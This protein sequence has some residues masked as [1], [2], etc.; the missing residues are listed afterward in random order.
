MSIFL[1]D[2]PR[3]TVLTFDPHDP[4]PPFFAPVVLPGLYGSDEAAMEAG[5]HE[6]KSLR[7]GLRHNIPNLNMPLVAL[8]DY[9]G[10]RLIATSI[11]PI[12][13]DTLIY[14]SADQGRTV[15]KDD[16]EF[17]TIMVRCRVCC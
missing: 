13:G 11:L 17:N 9:L 6:L 16:D 4:P 14:G 2:S 8:V 12:S 5:A 3:L 15:H 7:Q 1:L 10:L